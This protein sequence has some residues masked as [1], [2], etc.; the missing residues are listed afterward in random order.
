MNKPLFHKDDLVEYCL[1]CYPKSHGSIFKVIKSR[2]WSNNFEY[3]CEPIKIYDLPE[4]IRWF[5][6]ECFKSHKKAK[7]LTYKRAFELLKCQD[8]K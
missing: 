8:K 7:P 1:D 4:K 2:P 3:Y 5:T 6:Q